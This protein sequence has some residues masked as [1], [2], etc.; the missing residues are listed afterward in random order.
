MTSLS[1]DQPRNKT[2]LLML[3]YVAFVSLGLPAGLLG[4]AWPTLRSEF[5]LPLDAIGLM[6]ISN[7]VGYLLSSLFIARLISR[8]GIGQLL[9]VSS[10]ASAVSLLGTPLAP[11]WLLIIL[12]SAI[13]GFGSGVL[14]AGLN[15]YLAA[16]YNE[17][18]M[19]WLHASFGV[20]ATLSP[21]IVTLSLSMTSS[22]RGGY[23]FVGA[24]MVLMVIAFAVTQSAWKRSTTTAPEHA[25]NDAEHGLMDFR[26]PL[27]ETLLRPVT[28]IGIVM[29]LLYC[30]AEFTL[31]SWTYTLFTEGRGIDPQ[32]AGLW[33]GGFW[34][35]FTIGRIMAG[36]F[37][38]RV[39]LH[40]LML[41]AMTTALVG[42]ALFWWNPHPW[43]SVGGVFLT[44]FAIAPI[45]ASLISST[46]QRV[47][48][49]HAANTIG[50]Q[51]ASAVLGGAVLPSVTGYLAQRVSLEA[52][53]VM[54]F[55][56]LAGLLAL[57][58]A[59]MGGQKTV[60]DPALSSLTDSQS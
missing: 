34:G 37:A 46:S 38:H 56:A 58:V 45:F 14:D 55:I 51:V 16:E 29:F 41:G 43:V 22:W 18:Q 60:A 42:A 44:G 27:R 53:P 54:L 5:A 7:T 9:I 28:W 32:L 52:V 24:V 11:A 59:S 25:Q 35:T 12:L 4:V 6:F 30:G 19:Q 3:A 36:L 10:L 57:Y 23:L 17:G 8:F 48:A 21:L 49:R 2:G 13:G 50:I 1:T 40:T 47:G 26:T 31:G 39:K 15:T 33:A 20:G